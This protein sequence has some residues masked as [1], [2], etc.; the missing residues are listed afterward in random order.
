MADL[1]PREKIAAVKSAAIWAL[2]RIGARRAAV[3]PA[4]HGRAGRRGRE[5]GRPS[6]GDAAGSRNFTTGADANL[7]QDGR[8]LSRCF[9]KA[10]GRSA[11]M[12]E[13]LGR[14]RRTFC[15]WLPKGANWKRP[16]KGWCSAKACRRGCGWF[17]KKRCQEPISSITFHFTIASPEIGS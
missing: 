13:R 10:A 15:N 16:N 4:E 7:P 17:D 6:D 1:A 5:M 12:A 3:W 8:P 9:G 14:R 2:G 11:G